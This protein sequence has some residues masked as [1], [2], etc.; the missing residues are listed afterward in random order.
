LIVKCE[1][2]NNENRDTLRVKKK[3]YRAM[4]TSFLDS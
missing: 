4:E 3:S 2:T 1:A